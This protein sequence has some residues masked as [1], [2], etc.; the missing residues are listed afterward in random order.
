VA[1][2]EL[3][4]ERGDLRRDHAAPH[5]P[6]ALLVEPV[7]PDEGDGQPVRR[8]RDLLERG[9]AQAPGRPRVRRGA[10]HLLAP[11]QERD[12]ALRAEPAAER[13]PGGGCPAAL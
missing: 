3:L 9:P 7:Q 1:L 12:G 5:P 6:A 11:R 8:A 4:E 2:C 10:L 13:N